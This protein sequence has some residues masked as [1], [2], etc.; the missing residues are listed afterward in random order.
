[1]TDGPVLVTVV[2]ANT[3]NEA[4]VPIPTGG[5]AADAGA[6]ASAIQA[7][8]AATSMVV[9]AVMNQRPRRVRPIR[10][11]EVIDCSRCGG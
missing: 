5:S 3:A 11:T 2:P 6:P 9:S 4:A 8:T 10:I 7:A 1:M